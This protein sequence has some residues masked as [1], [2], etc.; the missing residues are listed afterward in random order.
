MPNPSARVIAAKADMESVLLRATTEG[1]D[2]IAMADY[3]VTY[4]MDSGCPKE[5]RFLKCRWSLDDIPGSEWCEILDAIKK[6][7]KGRKS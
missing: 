5:I 7:E 2:R 3:V 6:C 1:L 4:R